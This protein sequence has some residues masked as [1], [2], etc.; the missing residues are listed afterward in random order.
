MYN[1]LMFRATWAEGRDASS[2]E[3]IASV[4]KAAGADPDA[5]L[6]ANGDA[7]VKSIL[8]AQTER[9]IAEGAFGMPYFVLESGGVREKYFGNDRLEMIER[10]LE[11]GKPWPAA[12]NVAPFKFP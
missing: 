12:P 9:A 2:P 1:R 6:A 10:R 5:V 8:K 7:E 4:A 3:V 11:R